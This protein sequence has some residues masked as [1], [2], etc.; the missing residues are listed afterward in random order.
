MVS[1]AVRPRVSNHEATVYALVIP[2]KRNAP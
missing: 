2:P 1:S